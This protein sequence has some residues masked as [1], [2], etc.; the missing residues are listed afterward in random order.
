MKGRKTMRV[1]I[2]DDYQ[3]G[4]LAVAD[5]QSL[6][7]VKPIAFTRHIA[8]EAELVRSLAGFAVIIAM[9]ERTPFPA[10]VI[11]RLPDLRL[12]VTAGMRN[13][14]IDL[15]AATAGG[16]TV[17]GTEMLPYPTAELT[18]GLILAAAR[19][20][21]REEG[22]MRAGLWQSTLGI[23]LKGKTL[24]IIGLGRLGSQVAAVGK[25][26]GM[27]ILAWSQN[28][29]AER[30]VAAGARLVP[31]AE[32]LAQ[33]DIVTIHL[34]LSPRTRGL[35]A[36]ADLAAMKQTALLVNTSRGPIVDEAALIA[37]LEAG[38]IG[39]AALDVYDV[40]P[41]PA[42]HAL[43]RL[44]KTL[45][46]PHLGYVTQEGYRLVYGQ[47]VEAIR[48]YLAGAPIR[49]LNAPATSG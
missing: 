14:A 31:K 47:A 39:G 12:L 34:V 24:G 13:A 35:I 4:A 33:S 37:S 43:R 49:V 41:L 9:R 29:T 22:A 15:A 16:V 36:A 18:W 10:R 7:G 46:T 40:E 44:P 48:A 3:D 19:H 30:A 28:L 27:E 17:C 32:L 1:A 26:F 5:W 6:R 23:G 11:E 2:L 8:D 21:V 20:I 25:A 38:R 45:L 42:D